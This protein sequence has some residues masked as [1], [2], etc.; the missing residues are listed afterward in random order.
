[1]VLFAFE[2]AYIMSDTETINLKS[3]LIFPARGHARLI[4]GDEYFIREDCLY[5]F[6]HVW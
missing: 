2:L 4:S 3:I 1:M 6:A 5:N